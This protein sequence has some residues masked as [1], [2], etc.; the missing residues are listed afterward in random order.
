LQSI[1]QGEQTIK[2]T[3]FHE[4]V[5]EQVKIVARTLKL[6]IDGFE[7]V[8]PLAPSLGVIVDGPASCRVVITI[9]KGDHAAIGKV[10]EQ[11]LRTILDVEPFKIFQIDEG[12]ELVEIVV[13]RR[14]L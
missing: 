1:Q 2:P 7:V 14:P 8:S 6:P 10:A 4:Q 5:F 12:E 9:P 13:A 11:Q 3:P